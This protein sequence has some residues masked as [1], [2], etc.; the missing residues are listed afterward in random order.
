MRVHRPLP[1]QGSKESTDETAEQADVQGPESQVLATRTVWPQGRPSK[2]WRRSRSRRRARS[3]R[4]VEG[5]H[6]V[7][8]G[9]SSVKTPVSTLSYRPASLYYQPEPRSTGRDLEGGLD[10]GQSNRQIAALAV[11]PSCSYVYRG[12]QYQVR[13]PSQG[14]G[15]ACLFRLS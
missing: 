9:P 4:A 7:A 15:R 13:T 3:Q 11:V 8:E 6:R 2:K 1:L 12:L 10:G 14:S 5:T